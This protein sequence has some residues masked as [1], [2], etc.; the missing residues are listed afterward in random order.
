MV[1][2]CEF[3][4]SVYSFLGARNN[5]KTNAIHDYLFLA[6]ANIQCLQLAKCRAYFNRVVAGRCAA[7]QMVAI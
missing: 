3:C 6:L 5:V 7:L 4:V 1:V 2:V